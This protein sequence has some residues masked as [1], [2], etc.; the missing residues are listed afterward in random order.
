MEVARASPAIASR[1]ST[2]S[3]PPLARGH[4]RRRL[5]GL[6]PRQDELLLAWG[7]PY[8]FD[9]FR[10]HMTLTTR[11][12]G[13]EADRLEAAARHRFASLLDEPVAIDT[14]ALFV[15]REPGGP[16]TI[17]ETASLLSD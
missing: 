14:L 2:P 15:E 12:F 9:E 1:P 4:A 10:F 8:V 5:A 13:A 6:T 11:V 17:L 7:Y 3:A 16:F